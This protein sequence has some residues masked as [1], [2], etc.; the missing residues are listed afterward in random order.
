MD[1]TKAVENNELKQEFDDDYSPHNWHNLDFLTHSPSICPA[2]PTL[3]TQ[4]IL[5]SWHW[6]FC[7]WDGYDKRNDQADW[8][9]RFLYY[10]H[11]RVWFTS[12]WLQQTNLL[13][14]ICP[15]SDLLQPILIYT[16]TLELEKHEHFIFLFVA[17]KPLENL[18][19]SV[20]KC[21]ANQAV[22][23]ALKNP[24][25][26]THCRLVAQIK[27]PNYQ[28]S[29]SLMPW[30]GS[31][32]SHNQSGPV[33]QQKQT[34]SVLDLLFYGWALLFYFY[35]RLETAGLHLLVE[36]CN[37]KSAILIIHSW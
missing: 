4:A 8:W 26:H 31:R 35:P 36:L 34:F 28:A 23:D 25:G 18:G 19:I 30:N 1:Y 27:R 5:M 32:V 20:P 29:P 14:S 13:W 15:I 17:I 24:P 37:I 11:N 22:T 12:F 6:A 21:T 33:M 9:L 16:M 10:I 2:S 7:M 3:S